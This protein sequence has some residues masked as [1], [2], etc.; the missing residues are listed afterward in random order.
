MIQDAPI[1]T[2]F[3]HALWGQGALPSPEI[4]VAESAGTG[5]HEITDLDV[6]GHLWRPFGY[7]SRLVVDCKSSA[8]KKGGPSP[9]SRALWVRGLM[10]VVG[11]EAGICV[12]PRAAPTDHR[13]TARAQHVV[14]LAGDQVETYLEKT[15]G[16]VPEGLQACD[17]T[18]WQA[19]RDAAARTER[20][21]ELARYL[22]GRYWQEPAPTRIRHV[23]QLVRRCHGNWDS[24]NPSHKALMSEAVSLFG[25][26][27]HEVAVTLFDLHLLPENEAALSQGL[28][29]HLYGGA[30]QYKLLVQLKEYATRMLKKEP[31]APLFDKTRQPSQ[32]ALPEWDRLIQL[33]RLSFDNLSSFGPACQLLRSIAFGCFLG[34]VAAVDPSWI[35]PRLP[36][37]SCT[38]A[39]AISD[40]V[41]R[42]GQVP[43][44]I[45]EELQGLL[46]TAADQ[47]AR[48]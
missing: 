41:T 21:E 42:A 46:V 3:L 30:D 2:R 14:L 17:H 47:T 45:A 31:E 10:N 7:T 1:K 11:A 13:V 19:F 38:L 24:K 39:V 5:R 23:L 36:G 44:S 32:V 25:L 35:F 33:V 29:V 22:Y 12:V 20:Q 15:T 18:A 26:A 28:M 37:E 6:L 9:I 40:Y 8:T 48:A 27:L 43:A 16:Q 4:S 34:G